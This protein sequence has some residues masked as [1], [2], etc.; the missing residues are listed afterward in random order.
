MYYDYSCSVDHH[1][2]AYPGFSVVFLQQF[3]IDPVREFCADKEAFAHGLMRNKVKSID[4]LMFIMS[5][6][7]KKNIRRFEFEDFDFELTMDEP[8]PLTMKG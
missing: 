7:E 8:Y 1:G 6:D 3:S 2:L 4:D 5:R